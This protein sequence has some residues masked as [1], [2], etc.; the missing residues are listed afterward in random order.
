MALRGLT[1]GADQTLRYDGQR[2]RNI[3]LN[4]G[5]AICRLYSASAPTVCPY[6][7]DADQDAMLDVAVSMKVKVLRVKAFPYFPSWWTAGVL[8]GKTVAAATSGDREAHYLKI[9]SFLAKCRTR[10][11]G[12]ILNLFFRHAT[13]SDL[14]GQ[15]IRAG[16]LIAGST[17]RNFVQAVT[18]EVATRYLSE[19]AVFGYEWSNEVNHRND[20][21]DASRGAWPV[22]NA[23]YGTLASYSAAAD[24]LNGG[25]LASV[26]TWWAG[27]IAAIDPNRIVLT[28]NGPNSYSMPGGSAGISSPMVEWHKEQVRDN[29][30]NCG[31]IHW[32]GNIGYS[33]NGF[34]GLNAVLTGVRHWQKTA[35]RAFV[36]G[37]FG[38]QPWKMTNIS[39][40][41][42]VVTFTTDGSFPADVGDRI[43]VCGTGTALDGQWLTV[44]TIN[45]GRTSITAPYGGSVTWSGSVNGLK[46]IDGVKM[47]RICDDIINSGTDVALWW[48][49]DSD[50][51]RPVGESI[52]EAGNEEL[53]A[54]I[55]AA[56]TRLGW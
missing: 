54:A 5:W 47:T 48:M 31:S 20:A 43:G 35:G 9:D 21:S 45:A 11:I 16:W 14:C 36:L 4:Y 10:G 18:Q 49:L 17:T 23:A 30:T 33:S 19:E 28:G 25:D 32:Y 26:V 22:T 27:V 15:S 12:V 52:D 44:A 13:A 8:N 37:E 42:G 38:N 39:T 46:P 24:M 29:P 55:L 56:N 40:S 2:F 53:R 34:K 51:A 1:V 7:P 3:G 6:T 41:G 50:T